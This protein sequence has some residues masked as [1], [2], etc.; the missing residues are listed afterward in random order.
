[1]IALTSTISSMSG[2]EKVD[3]YISDI[4]RDGGHAAL[5]KL[6]L[7]TKD[8]VYGYALSILKNTHDAEDVLHDCYISV[9][10]TAHSYVSAG[11]PMAWIFTI[12]RNLCLSKIRSRSR[13]ADVPEEDWERYLESNERVSAEDKIILEHCLRDL[14]D[15]EREIL[16]LHIL[17]GMKHRE[18]A[19]LLNRPLSTILSKYHRTLKKM[20]VLLK[21]EDGQNGQS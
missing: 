13:F 10:Q 20:R 15:D 12:T 6:Y 21:E 8:A 19:E 11:K 1:M 2:M 3:H 17:S 14:A 4:A 7:C 16:L 9:Y 18:I 5:E